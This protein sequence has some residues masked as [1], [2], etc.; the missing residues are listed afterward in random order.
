[1]LLLSSKGTILGVTT[2]TPTN[3]ELQTCPH[4][5]CSSAHEWDLQNYRFPKSLR[6]V[7]KE[8]SRKI[9]AVMTEG[10]SPEL[11]DTDSDSNSVEQIYDIGTMTSRMIGS[12]KVVSITSRNVSETKETVQDVPQA[13]TLHSKVRN[14]TI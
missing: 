6:T 2:R 8:I 12:V 5:I 13:N 3:K 14:S 4:V 7:E 1:M 9:G 11:T 10:G